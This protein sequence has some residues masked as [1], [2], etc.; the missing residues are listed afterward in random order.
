MQTGTA[1]RETAGA[2][3]P[4]ALRCQLG[5]IADDLDGRLDPDQLAGLRRFLGMKHA[6]GRGRAATARTLALL[7]LDLRD[8]PAVVNVS[9]LARRAGLS[10]VTTHRALAYVAAPTVGRPKLIRLGKAYTS[11]SGRGGRPGRWQIRSDILEKT[12]SQRPQEKAASSASVN[13]STLLPETTT[14]PRADESALRASETSSGGLRPLSTP[15]QTTGPKSLLAWLDSPALDLNR[16]PTFSERRKMAAAL[17][18]CEGTNGEIAT[19][20]LAALFWRR[21]APLRVWR[22]AILALVSG[23]PDRFTRPREPRRYGAGIV[24][25]GAGVPPEHWSRQSSAELEWRARIALRVLVA[26]PT[27]VAAFVAA[28]ELGTLPEDSAPDA[29]ARHIER[30]DAQLAAVYAAA[31]AHGKCPC[32]EKPVRLG[33]LPTTDERKRLPGTFVFRVLHEL[34]KGSRFPRD[35]WQLPGWGAHTGPHLCA[36][37]LL[38]KRW[39]LSQELKGVQC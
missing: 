35:N 34:P 9:D 18:L 5:P 30:I 25:V 15:A 4:A 29:L 11:P 8:G 14:K 1:T 36:V 12:A 32:C 21:S 39:E 37:R 7:F 31:T 16:A 33:P 23:V 28:L 24:E 27:A 2:T 19:A 17:R 38:T 26:D 10:R 13:L 20:T 6:A 22:A 3:L